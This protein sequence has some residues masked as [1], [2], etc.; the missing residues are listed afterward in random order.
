[1]STKSFISK[2]ENINYSQKKTTYTDKKT[3]TIITKS[4]SKSNNKSSNTT[5][6]KF[7]PIS[8]PSDYSNI[9]NQ[10]DSKML[11]QPILNTS[12]YQRAIESEFPSSSKEKMKLKLLQYN[13][14][15]ESLD[16]CSSFPS[17]IRKYIYQ[18]LF[19]LPNQKNIYEKYNKF[20]IHPFYRFLNDIYPLDDDTQRKNLQKVCSLLAF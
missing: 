19:S 8:D 4:K 1:M 9:Q 7:Y 10:Y 5:T 14:I 15:K 2:N 12:L 11:S 13:I 20:G 6:T 16:Q 17:N 3:R 18:F